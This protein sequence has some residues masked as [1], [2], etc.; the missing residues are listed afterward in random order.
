VCATPLASTTG[1]RTSPTPRASRW[2]WYRRRRSSV[3]WRWSTRSTS[4]WV[5]RRAPS[6]SRSVM[7][8][9]KCSRAG[10]KGLASTTACAC[11]RWG[12][13]G[14]C[15][16]LASAYLPRRA[17]SLLPA[18]QPTPRNHWPPPSSRGI[19]TQIQ[20]RRRP[21]RAVGY[22]APFCRGCWAAQRWGVRSDRRLMGQPASILV[23]TSTRYA[24]GSTRR[25]VQFSTRV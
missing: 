24:Y 22:W 21:V 3:P 13:P 11:M 4:A 19:C 17:P 20:L 12:P 23:M 9:S 7:I 14:R 6:P 2:P 8:C 25:R 18:S 15:M 5:I 16:S 1:G 10:T